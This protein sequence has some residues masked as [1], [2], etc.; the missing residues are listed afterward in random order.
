M[1]KVVTSTEHSFVYSEAQEV[2]LVMRSHSSFGARLDQT[3]NKFGWEERGD[4]EAILIRESCDEALFSIMRAGDWVKID[5]VTHEI[6][7]TLD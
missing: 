1:I 2:H 3:R 5:G 4:E 6:C 7:K